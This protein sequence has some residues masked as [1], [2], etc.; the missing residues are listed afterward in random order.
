MGGVAAAHEIAYGGAALAH[1]ANDAVAREFLARYR[2]LDFSQTTP[3]NVFYT[4]CFAPLFLSLMIWGWRRHIMAKHTNPTGNTP[5]AKSLC[6]PAS[7][8]QQRPST[9]EP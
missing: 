4:I 1:H 2:W 3:R 8:D 6:A 7:L 9:R 5:N